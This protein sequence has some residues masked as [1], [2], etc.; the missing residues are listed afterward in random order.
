MV[1]QHEKITFKQTLTEKFFKDTD[2][3]K[4]VIEIIKKYKDD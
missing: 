3:D 2:A 4:D 1:D